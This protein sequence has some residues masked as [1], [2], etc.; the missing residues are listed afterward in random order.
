MPAR[1]REV[2][3]EKA[4]I[5]E[6]RREERARDEARRRAQE[7]VDQTVDKADVV[8]A[9]IMRWSAAVRRVERSATALQSC[10]RKAQ[11]VGGGF[12]LGYFH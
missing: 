2:R 9:L 5:R 8:G 11:S 6:A 12:I 4:T 1:L 10:Q 7:L 3:D